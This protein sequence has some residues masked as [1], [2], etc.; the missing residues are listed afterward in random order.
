MAAKSVSP[1][2]PPP[3]PSGPVVRVAPL[4]ELNAYTVY[5]HELDTLA[6]GSPGSNLLALSYALL[7]FAGALVIALIGTE[8]PS[9]RVYDAFVLGALVT[10]IAGGVCVVLGLAGYRSNKDLVAQIKGRMPP[11]A[12][13]LPLP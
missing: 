11:A 7:P 5:E 9:N 12:T 1:A 13:Q 6:A 8:I 10:G 3:P 4:G 2:A